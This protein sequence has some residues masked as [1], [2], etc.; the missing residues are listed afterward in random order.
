[1]AEKQVYGLQLLTFLVNKFDYQIVNIKGL[2]TEDYWLV[3]LK[4]KYPLVC[5][6]HENYRK[7]NI[8]ETLF[9]QVYRALLSTF[10]QSVKCL[11]L[12]TNETCS[13]FEMEDIRQSVILENRVDSSIM[14]DYPGIEQVVRNVDNVVD[15]KRKLTKVLQ[16]K[17]RSEMMSHMKAPKVTGIIALICFVVFM[18]QPF[19]TMITKDETVSAILSGA[20]YK[21]NVIGAYEY[22]RLLTAGFVHV[23]I[24]HL[25]MNMMALF[26]LGMMLE[27]KME[28]KHY[29]TTLLAS[30]IVG[31]IFVLL[32]DANIVGLG[33][34]G[35]LFGLLGVYT[36]MLFTEG[37][38]RNPRIISSFL[39][40]MM[41][42]VLISLLPNI[43]MLAHLGGFICGVVLGIYYSDSSKLM[44][45]KKH[46]V[47]AFGA[48][49]IGCV[50]SAPFISRIVP[51]YAKTDARI[52]ESA[53]KMNLDFYA[54][55]L[56]NRYDGQLASQGDLNYKEFLIEIISRGE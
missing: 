20:Y 3:N 21:M 39:T 43:S 4:H 17:A 23:D 22:W 31:N 41:M 27:M 8:M 24:W 51:V 5:I 15:E 7:E 42:N 11:V 34:S 54:N 55:Y 33:L 40:T 46:V 38:Y 29:V 56:L 25:F 13:D 36:V 2:S 26:N 12:N 35:G 47:T 45:I 53:Q 28:R 18:I 44:S 9:G 6:T 49:V 52:V 30:V 32:G 16:K 1:M 14:F 48:V 19:L 50:I 10:S 37:Y